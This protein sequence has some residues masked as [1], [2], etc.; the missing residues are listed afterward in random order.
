MV[1]A[2]TQTHHRALPSSTGQTR[3]TSSRVLFYGM[4]VTGAGLASV[5]FLAGALAMV[6]SLAHS[7]AGGERARFE[8]ALSLNPILRAGPG[9][10]NIRP[11]KF[12]RAPLPLADKIA[13][14]GLT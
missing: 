8:T 12:A 3:K 14:S 11:G 6:Q 2:G 4:A 5:G 7:A 13:A 10:R 9:E 1:S